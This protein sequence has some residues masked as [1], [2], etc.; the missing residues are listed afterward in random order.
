MRLEAHALADARG[1]QDG[2]RI[3]GHPAANEAQ[4]LRGRRVEPVGVV[5]QEQERPALG[6]LGNQPECRRVD[7]EPVVPLRRTEGQRS[8]ERGPLSRGKREARPD[9]RSQQLPERRERQIGLGLHAA[10]GEGM[11]TLGAGARALQQDALADTWLSPDDQDA[12]HARPS[13]SEEL[14]DDREVILPPEQ[15]GCLGAGDEA[16]PGSRR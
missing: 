12:S 5:D 7:A 6:G 13:V 3:A 8:L 11:H 10:D 4:R 14:P 9:D 16:S 2:D 15:T 1:E